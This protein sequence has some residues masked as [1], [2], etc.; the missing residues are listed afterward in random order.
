M[1]NGEIRNKII[2]EG[3]AEYKRQMTDAANAVK[4]LDSEQKLA[5]AQFRATG[6]AQQYAADQASI[7]RQKIEEQQKAVNAA[8]AAVN[9]LTANGVEPN[10]RAM[11][12]WRTKLN[13]AKT[14]LTDL[15][16]KLGE[17]E[18]DLQSQGEAFDDTTT[19]AG[20][21]KD[22]LDKIE[23]EVRFQNTIQAIDTLREG[24]AKATEAAKEFGVWLYNQETAAG[25]WADNMA[26]AAS[27]AGI[28]VETYQSWMYASQF[29]DTEVSAII[30]NRE[31]LTQKLT[32]NSEADAK[33]FNDLGVATRQSNGDVRDATQV[34]WDCIDALGRIEDPTK[35]AAAAEDIFGKSWRELQPLIEAGSAAYKELAEAGRQVAVVSQENV[36]K[37]GALDDSHNKVVSALGKT[38]LTLRASVAPAFTRLNEAAAAALTKFNEWAESPAGQEALEKLGDAAVGL[39]E[40]ITEKD[41]EGWVTKATEAVESLTGALDWI[42]QN[43]AT[44]TSILL[45]MGAA[46][47]GLT[48]TKEVLTFAH[49]LSN[50]NWDKIG[51]S[52]GGAGAV[53]AAETAVETAAE[54]AKPSNFAMSAGSLLMGAGAAYGLYKADE[55]YGNL[56]GGRSGLKDIGY[57][58]GL[59]NYTA[60]SETG[61]QI[62]NSIK[63]AVTDGMDA[64]QFTKEK[65][66]SE[67]L[68]EYYTQKQETW[69]RWDA[70]GQR[71]NAQQNLENAYAQLEKLATEA[72]EKM[73]EV[74]E[75][76]QKTGEEAAQALTDAI[77]QNAQEAVD[78]AADMATEAQ[79]ATEQG[80]SDMETLGYNAAIGV[81]NGINMG[82]V[83]AI[84]AANDLAMKVQ[85]SIQSALDIHSPSRVM[86]QLGEYV[87]Q[88]FA[89]GIERNIS[90][91]QRA[92]DFVADATGGGVEPAPAPA[93]SRAYGAQGG[94][95]R[96]VIQIDKRQL[97]EVLVDD[98]DT[99]L[100]AKVRPRR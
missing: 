27:Q 83:E 56:E 5:A 2:L 6:D 4:T 18:E 65:Y 10:S 55:L 42:S 9:Q 73:S 8:Q 69:A 1:A 52:G 88:G 68:G 30:T 59:Y 44:I 47:A 14:K 64:A 11:Q 100:A 92:M 41:F 54:T 48:V 25:Q 66:G 36:D 43:G 15:Q 21:Y 19:D 50:I 23:R 62:Y 87:S 12:T 53:N 49:L 63:Q 84:G 17:T 24:L 32:S 3:E 45:G 38:S 34:F 51:K 90:A 40:S 94:P 80:L 98:M 35:R 28:D 74:V 67:A 33:A 29:I 7:L 60:H 70:S 57:N 93:R 26:T 22:Q 86:M 79:E 16:T 77:D 85:Q 76:A 96:V 37:L 31:R 61:E 78:A 99:E 71:Y 97:A 39:V 72:A 82:A 91:V 58:L 20:E 46:W 95:R 81:A 75:E 13:D 89:E